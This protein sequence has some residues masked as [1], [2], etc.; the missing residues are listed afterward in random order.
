MKKHFTLIEL[1][2]SK[3]CQICVYILRKMASCLDTCRCNSSKCGIVGFADA[4][5]A[6]HQKFLARMD[7]VR[8]RKGEPFFKKGSLPSP[9]P[10]TLIELLVVIAII[11]IL[12]AMLLPALTQARDRA[13]SISCLSNFNQVGKG[14]HNYSDDNDGYIMVYWNA[15]SNGSFAWVNDYSRSW[16]EGLKKYGRL[17]AY[18]GNNTVAP[19]GGVTQVGSNPVV[20]NLL[21]CPARNLEK[22]LP[23][24]SG[25]TKNCYSYGLAGHLGNGR[26]NGCKL[27][28][29][30]FTSRN[31][32]VGESRSVVSQVSAKYNGTNYMVFPHGGNDANIDDTVCRPTAGGTANMLFIDGH[33]ESRKRSEV[34][35]S[36]FDTDPERQAQWSVFWYHRSAGKF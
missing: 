32:Y 25:T 15:L 7:G 14:L 6:I 19:V 8:G 29:L 36:F 30:R 12:A 5:T 9:A 10:F 21:I 28:T 24:V 20:R 4:K 34:P 31:I 2:V 11:A 1:L 35:N 16:G 33:S 13:K 17:G 26:A 22:K 18:I 3:T 27:S 23:E